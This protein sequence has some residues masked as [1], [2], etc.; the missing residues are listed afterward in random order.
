M[1]SISVLLIPFGIYFLFQKTLTVR[2]QLL[3]SG[4]DFVL[5]HPHFL[6]RHRVR[7]CSGRRSLFDAGK[8]SF[9][10]RHLG[11]QLDSGNSGRH[12]LGLHVQDAVPVVQHSVV[13]FF[14]HR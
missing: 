12:S 3:L 2:V 11:H 1:L 9:R 13:R 8:T 6:S 5:G 10:N 7:L 14:T 4:Q